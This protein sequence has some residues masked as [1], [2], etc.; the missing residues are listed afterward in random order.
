MPPDIPA[1]RE[2]VHQLDRAVMLNLQS[3][4]QFADPWPNPFR[5]SLERQHQLVLMGL[6]TRRSRRLLAEMQEFSNLVPQLRQRLIVGLGKFFFHDCAN[7]IVL[8]CNLIQKHAA[9]PED[10]ILQQQANARA[11][12]S[13]WSPASPS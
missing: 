3:L 2:P 11:S 13:R 6:N 7:Y 5:Q 8:R 12:G 10:P 1:S 4:R 9:H